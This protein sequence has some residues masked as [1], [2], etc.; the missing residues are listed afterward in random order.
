MKRRW[1]VDRATGVPGEGVGVVAMI[2]W[3]GGC[4]WYEGWDS[5]LGS[6][7]L[8]MN[9]DG[10]LL[11]ATDEPAD[12]GQGHS[13]IF[14]QMAHD[15]L[16]VPMSRIRLAR[17]DTATAPWGLGT[18]GSRSTFIHGA[19]LLRAGTELRERLF[20]VAAHHLEA[21]ATDLELREDAIGVRGTAT[22]VDLP[23][24]AGMIHADRKGMPPGSEP[25]ALVA[26]ASYDTPTEV[27]DDHG[28]G[29][30]SA[31]YTC[32]A[33]AAHVRVDPATGKVQILDWASAEDVGR[34]LHP[35]APGGPDSRRNRPG[36][37]LRPRRDAAVR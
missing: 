35:E 34:I 10:S 2:E 12:S 28:Y 11:I 32:S 5:D 4:R 26:T 3:G 33:T 21:D 25:S 1:L 15:A 13:T 27:P 16:G 23:A 7:T 6:V 9:A 14:K 17:G 37:R 8:T 19:A 20:R 31:V 24:L 30:F 22:S 18:Y 29:H 36:D